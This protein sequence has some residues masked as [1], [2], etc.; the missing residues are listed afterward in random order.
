MP[1]AYVQIIYVCCDRLLDV[2][3]RTCSDETHKG[4]LFHASNRLLG[5]TTS[6]PTVTQN[7]T[8]SH[9]S[10]ASSASSRYFTNDASKPA[11]LNV[12]VTSTTVSRLQVINLRPSVSTESFLPVAVHGR[13]SPLPP[14][15]SRQLSSSGQLTPLTVRQSWSPASRS[16]DHESL[17]GM[18]TAAP[19]RSGASPAERVAVAMSCTDYPPEA[20]A[21]V[22]GYKQ[23]LNSSPGEWKRLS[24][25]NDA[26]VLSALMWDWI[27]ELKVLSTTGYRAGVWIVGGMGPAPSCFP[28]PPTL[29]LPN[30]L[31][32]YVFGGRQFIQ[33]M[34][35][36]PHINSERI[37][38][39]TEFTPSC[40]SSTILNLATASDCCGVCTLTIAAYNDNHYAVIKQSH[41]TDLNESCCTNGV[42]AFSARCIV[43]YLYTV[44]C[45]LR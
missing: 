45:Y 10:E 15:T 31:S 42:R 30:T 33:L 34:H 37:P 41:I 24:L 2:A 4:L 8:D 44:I 17:P 39:A 1:F 23:K 5:S 11:T 40:V 21:K 22:E 36:L 14:L 6:T 43:S 25:E 19:S 3:G 35:N 32:D 38:A 29:R 26:H 12:P 28:N 27:D 18:L 13:L 16:D 7:F 9:S 20:L